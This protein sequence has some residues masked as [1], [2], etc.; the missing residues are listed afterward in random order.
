I[1]DWAR[2]DRNAG[3]H[4]APGATMRGRRAKASSAK[5][6]SMP[7]RMPERQRSGTAALARVGPDGSAAQTTRGRRPQPPTP[8]VLPCV[9]E[10][11]DGNLFIAQA[12]GGDL[13]ADEGAELVT[14]L[15]DVDVHGRGDPTVSCPE[16]DEFAA[17]PIAPDDDVVGGAAVADVFHTEVELIGVEVRLPVVGLCTAGDRR[18]RDFGL[19]DGV[20]PVLDAQTLIAQSIPGVRDVAD[21]QD[22]SV[23]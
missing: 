20:V 11:A 6:D 2:S 15:P 8:R 18:R 7:F 9:S 16:H 13:L 5:S 12:L 23:G 3:S 22:A 1:Q 10:F 21:G 17:G 4:T 19:P 14:V